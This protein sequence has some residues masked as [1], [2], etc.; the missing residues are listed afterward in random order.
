MSYYGN[1]Y[2]T[3]IIKYYKSALEKNF[4]P[5]ESVIKYLPEHHCEDR[6]SSEKIC[7]GSHERGINILEGPKP[8]GGKKKYSKSGGRVDV[9]SGWML[10]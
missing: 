4:F 10:L 5:R 9:G 6:H 8:H 1:I 3:E 7:K 2:T